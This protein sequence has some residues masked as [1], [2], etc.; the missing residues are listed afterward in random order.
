MRKFILVV[1]ALAIAIPALAADRPPQRPGNW[2]M[3]MQM[4]M[5][6]MPFK[7][8][9]VKM[10]IC[11]TEEDLKDPNKAVPGDPK[12]KCT[13]ND[14]KIDGNKV[15]WTVD[16]PKQKMKGEGEATYTENS[17]TANV[18]MTMEDREMTAK[19]SGKW[20]GECSK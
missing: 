6:G 10:T 12:S 14:Y 2:E 7:M 4:D 18:H 9:P 3:T 16:C 19:Y 8:P 5:P 15:T 1:L 13:V 11:I 17:F 20:K